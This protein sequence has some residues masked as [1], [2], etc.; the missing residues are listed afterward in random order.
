MSHK[1]ID[2]S[3]AD[4]TSTNTTLAVSRTAPNDQVGVGQSQAA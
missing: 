4:P 2:L 1:F 3:K